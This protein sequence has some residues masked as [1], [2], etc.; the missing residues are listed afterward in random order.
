MASV[1]GPGRHQ[2]GRAEGCL[3]WAGSGHW[4]MLPL[5]VSLSYTLRWAMNTVSN[6]R[7]WEPRPLQGP[8]HVM[9]LSYQKHVLTGASKP[10][11][12]P[13]GYDR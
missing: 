12:D 8:A 4:K 10:S 1:G 9:F 7:R 13:S 5:D 2:N 6:G 3:Q 11:P